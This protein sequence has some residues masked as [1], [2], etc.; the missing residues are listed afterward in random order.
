MNL[1][2]IFGMFLLIAGV[3]AFIYGLSIQDSVE[4]KFVSAFSGD[5][6]RVAL[7]MIGGIVASVAGVLLLVFGRDRNKSTN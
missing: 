3:G 7:L 5:T 6:S 4:Y 2:Q 1:K